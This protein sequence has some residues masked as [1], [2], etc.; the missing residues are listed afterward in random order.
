MDYF[1]LASTPAFYLGKVRKDSLG[2][3]SKSQLF[4]IC[5]VSFSCLRISCF[6]TFS[7]LMLKVGFLASNV[8]F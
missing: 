6:I 8:R 2:N 1:F 3:V 7:A 4:G 5:L